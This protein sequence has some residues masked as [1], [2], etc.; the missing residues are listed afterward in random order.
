MDIENIRARDGQPITLAALSALPVIS[1]AV[2]ALYAWLAQRGDMPGPL[3]TS[4]SD[5]NKAG[6][7]AQP[8]RDP[9]HREGHVQAGR[10]HR[11]EQD[12]ALVKAHGDHQRHRESCVCH[13]R[14]RDGQA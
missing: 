9:H 2:E 12:D 1:E 4:I 14:A 5:R 7:L 13:E 11:R 6:R 3:F 8:E 10:R